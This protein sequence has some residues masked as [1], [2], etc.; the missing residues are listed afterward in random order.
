VE[1]EPGGGDPCG[2]LALVRVEVGPG[3]IALDRCAASGRL[4]LAV[5]PGEQEREVALF[6]AAALRVELLERL[7]KLV[8]E[9]LD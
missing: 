8:A 2:D 5:E 6:D 4:T 9:L 1:P 7:R 3:E